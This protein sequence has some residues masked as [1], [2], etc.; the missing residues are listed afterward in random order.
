MT[1]TQQFLEETVQIVKKID[2]QAVD[3]AASYKARSGGVKN[4]Q[5]AVTGLC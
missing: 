4:L 2:T 3:G 1:F 5:G